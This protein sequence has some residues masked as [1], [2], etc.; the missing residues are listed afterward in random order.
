MIPEDPGLKE[1][2]E[3]VIKQCDTRGVTVEV[4]SSYGNGAQKTEVTQAGGA[5]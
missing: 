1:N 4:V 2:F 5:E 3:E